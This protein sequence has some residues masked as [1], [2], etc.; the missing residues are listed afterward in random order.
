[1]SSNEIILPRERRN[2]IGN[3]DLV[4]KAMQWISDDTM[5]NGWMIT[6]GEGAGKATLA[7]KLA[8]ALLGENAK[9]EALIN[10]SAHPDLFVAER[11]YDEKKNKY[12]TDIKIETVR[13]LTSFMSHTASMGGWRVAIIDT[14]DHLNRNA[15]NALLKVLEEPPAKTTLFLLSASPGRLLPTI[16]SRCRRLDLRPLTDENVVRFLKNEGADGD[17]TMLAQ[18]AQGRPGYALT[19]S[20]TAGADAVKMVDIF[21]KAIE[22]NGDIMNIIQKLSLRSADE[23]WPVF[24]TQLLARINIAI[25]QRALQPNNNGQDIMIETTINAY[26]QITELLTRGE[27]IN[28]DRGQMILRTAQ[29]LSAAQ[30]T[31]T[32]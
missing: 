24:K 2:F 11:L 1:M 19:L 15:A 18:A 28:V 26:D 13:K 5:L 22:R 16:R 29:I 32:A 3:E 20:Q 23:M 25:R 31:Q 12:A 21:I 14:A 8:R 4:S 10:S 7:F 27:A 17:L 30:F 6:G 9:T